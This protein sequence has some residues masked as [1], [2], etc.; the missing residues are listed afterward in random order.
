MSDYPTTHFVCEYLYNGRWRSNH[1][2]FADMREA[3]IARHNL[4]QQYG[5]VRIIQ[6]EKLLVV[7]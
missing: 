5:Q 7:E 1:I 2:E 4:L 6:V 3:E